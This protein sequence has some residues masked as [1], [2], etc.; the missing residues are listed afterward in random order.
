MLLTI[1]AV[2]VVLWLLGWLAFNLGA[3]IH[4]LLVA[5][6]IV[7]IWNFIAGSRTRV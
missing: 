7:L 3:F 6:L 5:A 1:V 4:I 2:L